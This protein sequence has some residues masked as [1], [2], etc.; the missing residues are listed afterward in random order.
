MPEQTDPYPDDPYV[1]IENTDPIVW[2]GV[3][4]EE[5]SYFQEM[6][7]DALEIFGGFVSIILA[8]LLIVVIVFLLVVLAGWIIRFSPKAW[9]IL[10]KTFNWARGK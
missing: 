10:V 4:L 8:I 2:P 6:W 3:G 1:F 9:A 7:Q 5:N